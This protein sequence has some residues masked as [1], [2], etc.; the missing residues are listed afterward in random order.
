LRLVHFGTFDVENYGDLLYPLIARHRLA[1]AGIDITFVSPVGGPPVW[2]DCVP[3]VDPS[4]VVEDDV[5][6]V[7]L[8]GGNIVH[9][10]PAGVD[11]YRGTGLTAL[12][13]YTRLWLKPSEIAN[14]RGIPL[15]WNAPGVPQA[16]SPRAAEV[17]RWATARAGYLSVRDSPS[18]LNLRQAG[19]AEA[20]EVVPDSALEVAELWTPAEL[21]EAR[22]ALFRAARREVPER[23]IVIHLNQR[24]ISGPAQSLAERLDRVAERLEATPVLLALGPC[25]GDDGVARSVGSK[26]KSGALVIDRPTGLR[27]IVAGIA[28]AD[29][30]LGSSMHGMITATAFGR[31]GVLVARDPARG[32][33]FSGFMSQFQLG[34]WLAPGW[35]EAEELLVAVLENGSADAAH[36]LPAAKPALDVHWAR[37]CDVLL[38]GRRARAGSKSSSPPS[39]EGILEEGVDALLRVADKERRRATV[40]SARAEGARQRLARAEQ[41]DRSAAVEKRIAEVETSLEKGAE[42]Q[43]VL[44]RR[45]AELQ[46]AR[47]E[48]ERELLAAKSASAERELGLQRRM[49]ELETVREAAE[50]RVEATTAEI[51]RRAAD[52][53][54]L[55]E[56]LAQREDSFRAAMEAQAEASRTVAR[57][58]EQLANAHARY[59]EDRAMA[60]RLEVI[61]PELDEVRAQL[62][63]SR[64]R[65]A[66]RDAIVSGLS[67]AIEQARSDQ[68]VTE[69]R[70]RAAEEELA[71]TDRAGHELEAEI[72]RM[73]TELE[74]LRLADDRAEAAEQQATRLR[75]EQER[76]T[77]LRDESLARE[78]ALRD[79]LVLERDGLEERLESTLA[80]LN[81]ARLP[82]AGRPDVE[83]LEAER[84]TL[85]AELLKESAAR[86]GLEEHLAGLHDEITERLRPV[87]PQIEEGTVTPRSEYSRTREADAFS[88]ITDPEAAAKTEFSH[89]YAKLCRHSGLDR[90][91]EP[92]RALPWPAF[93]PAS[94]DDGKPRASVIVCVQNALDDVRR[95]LDSVARHLTV[96][97]E[98][99]LVDDG[100]DPTTADFLAGV[101]GAGGRVH[102]IANPE[103]PHG[104]TVAANLGLRAA[105]GEYLILLNSD[106]IVSAGWFERL[107]ACADSDPGIGIV[108][109]VSNA[110]SHQSVPKVREDG[111][112]ATNPLPAWLTAD[113]MAVAVACASPRERPRVPF[114]NGYCYLI[115]R[116][117]LDAVGLLDEENFA[118]GY[119]EENDFSIRARKVGFVG[120]I[121]D[122]AF[123]FHAKSR[124]YAS[125]GRNEHARRNYARFMEKHGA[126]TIQPLVDSLE[127]TPPVAEL[128]RRL[129]RLLGDPAAFVSQ[130]HERL[131][132]PVRPL[133]V[134]PGI[135]PAGS[136]GSHSIV[137]EVAGLRRIG[138]PARIAISQEATE[139]A[140]ATYP[141]DL[142][143]FTPYRGTKA[144]TEVARDANVI[145]ATHSDSVPLVG[146][147]LAERP[148]LLPA[149]YIQDYE[150]FFWE[151]GS[152]SSRRALASYNAL[153]GAC[154]FA[155]THWICNVVS[156]AHGVA[157]HKVEPSVDRSLYRPPETPS[158]ESAPVVIAAM[159]RPRTPRRQPRATLRVLE[160][161]VRKFG[162]GVD[163]ITFGCPQT[164]LEDLT[165][166]PFF[167]ERHRGVLSRPAVADLLRE[168]DVF[169][170]HSVYQAFGRT[171]LE[172]MACGC[173]PIA[174]AIGGAWEFVE[175]GVNALV[176][177]TH[178]EHDVSSA[179]TRLVEDAQLRQRLRAAGLGT[180]ARYSVER[181]AMSEF[182][183]FASMLLL[184]QQ[185][186]SAKGPA[187]RVG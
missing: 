78:R 53:R 29:A 128:S 121:A 3:T 149:Y 102:L 61:E 145:V 75:A 13:T 10:G 137:Q 134:L 129:E 31:P 4:A 170:D 83:L 100:S 72:E 178:D 147:V 26:M 161:L 126:E 71:E 95:C 119:C 55:T 139:H 77:E 187:A 45:L 171:A 176:C 98:V 104:Y 82:T 15:A 38:G 169:I 40:E 179:V 60:G 151:E 48:A 96:D 168:A 185:A 97:T 54:T 103:P 41:E 90:L 117:T 62:A 122:D 164:A 107:I 59:A 22:E 19:V 79:Q 130:V 66:E 70:L 91:H 18:L 182:A 159:I 113:G 76:A 131:G 166:M 58:E 142:E 158:E 28:G 118:A 124:S 160:R 14:A 112:W 111:A 2:A 177:E 44:Q 51:E 74:G 37:I 153:E 69:E 23:W 172:A 154:L 81:E 165:E 125:E 183:L 180:A 92:E 141:D 12:L 67:D 163:V 85:R 36:V 65:V 42:E 110:A 127:S 1:A 34:R 167:R 132:A 33:K 156:A 25:H 106:T 89:R 123:V 21:E 46:A 30:Y 155:K 120:A 173:V 175:P 35:A 43:R 99:V 93:P 94:R 157:V 24:Y 138:V 84:D 114:V 64:R 136:G 101:A 108:G 146:T 39:V 16:I 184:R 143:L 17:L 9:A 32:G 57:L 105:G 87:E 150:P 162:D 148:A 181:A 80:A 11:A 152:E 56:V 8:G 27:Q 144:V 5:D 174:P 49:T 47:D 86:Q 68:L 135:P 116:R 140:R 133:F 7:L 52:V 109:P 50:Q 115:T 73:S 186:S 63:E 20:V 6:G 88:D